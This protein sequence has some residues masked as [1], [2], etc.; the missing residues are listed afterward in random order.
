MR[1]TTLI[2]KFTNKCIFNSLIKVWG[3]ETKG[4]YLCGAW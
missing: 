3:L 1:P 4:N 2:N